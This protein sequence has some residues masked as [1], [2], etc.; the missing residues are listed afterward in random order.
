MTDLASVDTSNT[1][2]LYE[3]KEERKRKRERGEYGEKER[4]RFVNKKKGIDR[5]TDIG[6]ERWIDGQMNGWI[7]RQ[8][9]SDKRLDRQADWEIYRRSYAKY[10]QI[11]KEADLKEIG[12][13]VMDDEIT[14]MMNLIVERGSVHVDENHEES[15][16]INSLVEENDEV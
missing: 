15:I 3:G 10:C 13:R 14:K 1:T 2:H 12:L 8:R 9:D 4:H 16:N 11:D 5:Q 6:R 7:D